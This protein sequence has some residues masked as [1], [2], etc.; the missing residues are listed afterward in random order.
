M[1][2]LELPASTFDTFYLIYGLRESVQI[3]EGRNKKCLDKVAHIAVL[4]R[5]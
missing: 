3:H 5:K 2:I 4:L 1:G